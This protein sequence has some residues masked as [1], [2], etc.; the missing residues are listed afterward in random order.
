VSS[1]SEHVLQRT[2]YRST[3]IVTMATCVQFHW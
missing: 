1:A 3:S 2:Q